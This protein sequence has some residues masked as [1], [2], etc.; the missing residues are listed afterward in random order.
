MAEILPLGVGPAPEGGENPRAKWVAKTVE[1]PRPIS[2]L[3]TSGDLFFTLVTYVPSQA[4]QSSE[5]LK[6]ESPGFYNTDAHA[7][8]NA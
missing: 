4:A 5:P 1:A 6:K 8:P 2:V 7:T 3:G